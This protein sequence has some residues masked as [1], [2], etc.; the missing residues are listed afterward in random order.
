MADEIL[1]T[2]KDVLARLEISRPT[3]YKLMRNGKIAPVD[4]EKPYLSRRV[5]LLFKA[6]D[7][8]RLRTGR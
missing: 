8:E 7:V 1:L 6:E 2:T 5:R 3:L 4:N